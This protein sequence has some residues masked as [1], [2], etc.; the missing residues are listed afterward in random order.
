MIAVI[1][2][3]GVI[4]NQSDTIDLYDNEIVKLE[5]SLI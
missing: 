4:K 5:N 1:E 3:F 2:I